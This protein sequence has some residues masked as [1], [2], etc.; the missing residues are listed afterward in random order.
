MCVCV[1]VWT[2]IFLYITP[3]VNSLSLSLSLSLSHP[4]FRKYERIQIDR[5]ILI[6]QTHGLKYS[7]LIQI[8][9]NALSAG[10]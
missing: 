3:Y 4:F 8:I 2:Y 10:A 1:C 6:V 7:Y 5:K 9:C